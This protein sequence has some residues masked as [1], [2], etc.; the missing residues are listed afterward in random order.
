MCNYVGKHRRITILRLKTDIILLMTIIINN[1]VNYRKITSK[2]FIESK[3]EN[4]HIRIVV[5]LQLGLYCNNRGVEK[6]Q[7]IN[8]YCNSCLL[9]AAW[10]LT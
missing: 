2:E 1:F 6:K 7:G 8:N 9:F 10:L 3:T 4:D 5:R